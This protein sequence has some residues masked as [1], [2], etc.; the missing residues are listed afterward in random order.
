MDSN[1]IGGQN[2][3]I[4]GLGYGKQADQKAPVKP[5]EEF[6]TDW[7]QPAGDLNDVKIPLE[8]AP[9]ETAPAKPK[10]EIVTDWQMPVGEKTPEKPA[11]TES[12]V[13]TTLTM[14]MGDTGQ[15]ADFISWGIQHPEQV[16]INSK[17]PEPL[18]LSGPIDIIG[19]DTGHMADSSTAFFKIGMNTINSIARDGIFTVDGEQLAKPS[20]GGAA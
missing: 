15:L 7:Q 8:K 16:G 18:N 10:E 4:G 9:R 17:P 3:Y 19:F 11:S 2:T 12:R 20:N 13:P 6:V 5:Q 1:I 14:D